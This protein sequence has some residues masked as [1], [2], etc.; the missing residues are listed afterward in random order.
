MMRFF[1]L[2]VLWVAMLW[3]PVAAL[4]HGVGSRELDPGATKAMVFLYADGDPMAFA[5]VVVTTPGT[6][7]TVY[8]SARTDGRGQFAFVPS[9]PGVWEVAASD[10][11]GHRAVRQVTVDDVASPSPDR[12]ASSA[13]APA[14]GIGP[15]WREVI[16][17]LSLLANVA[18][19]AAL[20][21]RKYG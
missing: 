6:D 4:A 7:G 1:A 9:G 12:I 14:S 18:L 10:G 5:Q 8:Q 20:W 11:Q 19:A 17:G 2:G 3:H 13:S 16:I 21:R 15:G